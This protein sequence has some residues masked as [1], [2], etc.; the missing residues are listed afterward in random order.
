MNPFTTDH[1]LTAKS[2]WFDTR[3]HPKLSFVCS[4]FVLAMILTPFAFQSL[5]SYVISDIGADADPFLNSWRVLILGSSIAFVLS[6]AGSL[7]AVLLWRLFVRRW[8]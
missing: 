6:L 3:E 4:T 1:P 5:H 7:P 8:R 2:S